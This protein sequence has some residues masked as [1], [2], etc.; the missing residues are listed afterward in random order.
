M[1][2]AIQT[3]VKDVKLPTD[4]TRAIYSFL[5]PKITFEPY[6]IND[7]VNPVRHGFVGTP[8][9]PIGTQLTV[10][11]TV[12]E[13]FVNRDNVSPQ[14]FKYKHELSFLWG[15]YKRTRGDLIS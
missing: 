1:S 3:A 13:D 7:G 12:N 14:D 15:E 2:V 5:N 11:I 10:E 9:A 6:F 8:P 4:V